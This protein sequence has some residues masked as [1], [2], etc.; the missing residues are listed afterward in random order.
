M[1]QRAPDGF[2][3]QLDVVGRHADGKGPPERSRS[4]TVPMPMSMAVIMPVVIM[5]VVIMACMVMIVVMVVVRMALH[6]MVMTRCVVAVLIRLHIMRVHRWCVGMGGVVGVVRLSRLGRRGG[7]G[8]G[9][10]SGLVNR[11]RGQAGC[12]FLYP[13]LWVQPQGGACG[14]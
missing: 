12:V 3:D 10:A 4:M 9:H 13:A 11:K 6:V 1:R 7:L 5:P 14:P 2:N 8:H